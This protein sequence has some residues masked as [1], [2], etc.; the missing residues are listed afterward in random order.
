MR[1]KF[2]TLLALIL[3]GALIWYLWLKPYD[4]LV[5]MEV[6]TFPGAINQSL[7]TWS[8][9][10]KEAEV[11]KGSDLYEIDQR[12]QF[13][14][15]TFLYQWNVRAVNDS[16]SRIKV[17]ITDEN[18]SLMN[19]IRRPFGTTD[20]ERR[21]RNTVMDF[22]G[23]LQDHI[24]NFR[25]RYVGEEEMPSKYCAYVEVEARQVE[26]A[27]GMMRNYSMLSDFLAENE[28]ALNGQPFVHIIDWDQ[29]KDSIR[30]HFC[31]PIIKSDS[32]PQHKE[33][34][35]KQFEGGKAIKAEYNGNY[36]TSD[37]AWYV[38]QDQAMKKGLQVTGGPVEVFFNNPN[39]GGDALQWRAD[40]YLPVQE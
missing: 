22:Y 40:V 32:L 2:P 4:Y 29:K 30:Y 10:L 1:R 6:R 23:K 12:I 26:K 19:R 17:H 16:M 37:R 15:S 13:R 25:V 27:L 5:T 34:F 28:V 31:Y 18:N 20:F 38:L 7:K 33:I 39:M 9:T 21:S 11:L 8:L 3:V 35:Y 24:N 14:D 36:I